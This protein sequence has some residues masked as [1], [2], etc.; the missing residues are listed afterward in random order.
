MTTLERGSHQDIRTLY[1]RNLNEKVSIN[2]LKEELTKVFLR[3]ELM[4]KEVK[5]CHNLRLRGQAFVTLADS[6]SCDISIRV[7][8]TSMLFGKPMDI[9]LA[10]KNSDAVVDFR[11]HEKYPKQFEKKMDDY[12]KTEKQQRLRKREEYKSNIKKRSNED[13]FSAN[14]GSAKKRKVENDTVEP[15]K[16]LLLTGLPLEAE[17]NDLLEV[18]DKF[19]GFL[20]LTLVGIRH[21]AMIEFRTETDSIYCLEKIGKVVTVQKQECKLQFAKK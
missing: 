17:E 5:V 11:F 6:E 4:V 14:S 2:K 10:K 19:N 13:D 21:L 8:N 20:N 16:I 18:F 3:K 15:N 1:I 12:L 7:L 9:R